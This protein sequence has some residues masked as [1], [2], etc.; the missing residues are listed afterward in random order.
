MIFQPSSGL[1]NRAQTGRQG[2]DRLM[3]S[4][5]PE[6]D[7]RDDNPGRRQPPTGRPHQMAECLECRH[8]GFSD[9]RMQVAGQGIQLVANLLEAFVLP[10]NVGFGRPGLQGSAEFV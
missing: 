9:R 5:V 1:G 4:G 10:G 3:A 2:F 6:P 7:R 8:P